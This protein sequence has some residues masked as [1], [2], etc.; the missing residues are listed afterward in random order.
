MR[1]GGEHLQTHTGDV[2]HTLQEPL[3]QGFF[4]DVQ[5]LGAVDAAVIIHLLD[6]QPI[7]EGRDVGAHLVSRF[8]QLN[9]AQDFNGSSGDLGGDSQ[10]LEE[11]GLL[12]TKPGVLNRDGHLTQGDGTS[13]G[14]SG[15]FVCQQQIP[16]LSQILLGEDEA[17]VP[18]D[19]GKQ[20]LQR[21]V[22]F[23]VATDGLSHHGVFAH[24]HDVLAPQAQ[25]DGLHLLGADIVS[26]HDET[27]GVVI[28]Q[29]DDFQKVV[30]LP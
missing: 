12:W 26:P 27:L 17:H 22:V 25:T 23:Q 11:E 5:H 14:S 8:D 20:P 15:H 21:R 9:V 24:E 30:G 10:S 1:D 29:L 7:R 19:V 3:V 16:D 4:S 13:A 28:Q 2:P 6:D 18:T